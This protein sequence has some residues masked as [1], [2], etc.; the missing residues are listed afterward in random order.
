MDRDE[1]EVGNYYYFVNSKVEILGKMKSKYM[2]DYGV[3]KLLVSADELT[4]KPDL[5]IGDEIIYLGMYYGEIKDIMNKG[6]NRY[7][8]QYEDMKGKLVNNAVCIRDLEEVVECYDI[9]NLVEEGDYIQCEGELLWKILYKEY[10]EV[11]DEYVFLGKNDFDGSVKL[12]R[13]HDILK[14]ERMRK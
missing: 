7:I 3:Y 6:R 10:D 2:I 13:E 9:F 11:D 8:I 4:K 5:Y 14:I 12:V 1:V